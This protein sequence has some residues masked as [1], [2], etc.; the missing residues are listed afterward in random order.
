MERYMCANECWPVF[1]NGLDASSVLRNWCTVCI[2][3]RSTGWLFV[4]L[5]GPCWPDPSPGLFT[6]QIVSGPEAAMIHGLFFF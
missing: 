6:G 5:L 2:M 1:S 3:E 4:Q